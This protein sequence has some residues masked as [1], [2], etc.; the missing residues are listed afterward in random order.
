MI[1]RTGSSVQPQDRLAHKL[2][3]SGMATLLFVDSDSS[4]CWIDFVPEPILSNAAR[5]IL[6]DLTSLRKG[7]KE[8]VR[9]LQLGNIPW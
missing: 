8:Y 3:L 2:V 6:T 9:R 7:I 1:M 4:R 5:I